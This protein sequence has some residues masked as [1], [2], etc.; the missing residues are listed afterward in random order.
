M[1]NLIKKLCLTILILATFNST[2]IAQECTIVSGTF[3]AEDL[4]N[5]LLAIQY[6]NDRDIVRLQDLINDG[7]ILYLEYPIILPARKLGSALEG[8]YVYVEV[9]GSKCGKNLDKLCKVWALSSSVYCM[10]EYNDK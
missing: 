3:I 6:I 8:K 10:G 9:Y 7:R 4:L 5:L 2:T 1:A